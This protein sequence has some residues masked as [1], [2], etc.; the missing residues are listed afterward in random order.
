MAA[1]AVE[2]G[3]VGESSPANWEQPLGSGE[4][5]VAIA[6]ISPDAGTP[7]RRSSI[8]HARRTSSY[9]VSR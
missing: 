2:L 4:I 7:S 9:P 8:G 1:R 5:H 3:D 6:T